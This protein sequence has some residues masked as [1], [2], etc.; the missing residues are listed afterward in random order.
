[1]NIIDSVFT[2][3]SHILYAKS[4]IICKFTHYNIY[5]LTL[6]LPLTIIMT[7]IL[8]YPNR[9]LNEINQ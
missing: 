2:M 3:Q 8:I 6:F 7:K 9:S 5:T 4:H 1:M